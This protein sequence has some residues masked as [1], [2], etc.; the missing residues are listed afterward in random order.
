MATAT[1]YSLFVLASVLSARVAFVRWSAWLSTV[2][3][4]ASTF[5]FPE[6]GVPFW[7]AFLNRSI[8]LVLVWATAY[9]GIR[10]VTTQQQLRAVNQQLETLSRQDALTGL[11]NRR[12]FDEQLELEHRRSL[13]TGVPLA[14]LLVDADYFKPYNDTYGHAAGDE[15]LRRS[16]AT[17]GQQTKRAGELVA[18]YG[19]EEFAVLLPGVDQLEA[20]RRAD[21]LR[22]AIR[23]LKLPHLTSPFQISPL[24]S[25]WLWLVQN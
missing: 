4:L 2:L 6:A 11:S 3:L 1:L 5:F 19:G 16:A 10:L 24:A 21:A 17:L 25:M 8:A 13:R 14:L 9:L 23:A 7:I 12:H 20:P 15:C 18:R 22:G